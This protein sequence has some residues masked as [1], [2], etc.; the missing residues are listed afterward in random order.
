MAEI[1]LVEDDQFLSNALRVKL[2]K[3]GF[4]VLMSKNG[5]EALNLLDSNTPDL[6]IVDLVMPEMDGFDFM[7]AIKEKGLSIP[8]IVASNLSQKD[9]LDKAKALGA[10][11]FFIKSD[12]SLESL[13]GKV[14]SVLGL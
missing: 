11:D 4:E 13:V 12:M 2:E 8:I 3:E 9:D 1:L 6:I 5:Q 10:K 7:A 14:K